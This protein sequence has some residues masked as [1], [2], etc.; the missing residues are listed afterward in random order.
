MS[1][2]IV[3]R[4]RQK[5]EGI[6]NVPAYAAHS[7]GE[8]FLPLF[9]DMATPDSGATVLDAGCGSGKGALA[10]L[11]SGFDVTLYDLTP[12]GL[13]DEARRFPFLAGSLW[14]DL[15]TVAYCAGLDRFDYAY[16]CDVLEHVP[17]PFTML[18]IRRLLDVAK[19]GVFL[20]I[21]L[22]LDRFGVWVG[23]PLHQ[24]I[25]TFTDWRDAIATVGRLVEARDL[26]GTGVFY[27]EPTR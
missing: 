2:A 23:A 12:D 9:L 15:S 5:Y 10:L 6:W 25:M 26:L 21:S 3:D 20:S 17:A 8:Q 19:R 18:V 13:I 24:T 27:V 14:D 1:S 22:E 16:C 7:P 4:E 11:R